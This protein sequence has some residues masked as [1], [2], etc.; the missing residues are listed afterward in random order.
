MKADPDSGRFVAVDALD[1]N[2]MH[3]RA[4]GAE[5]MAQACEAGAA[6][7]RV[8]AEAAGEK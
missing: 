2:G 4:L 5:D 8:L 3:L 7:L 6:L 1:S